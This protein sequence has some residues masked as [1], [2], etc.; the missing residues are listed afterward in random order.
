MKLRVH[1]LERLMGLIVH[2]DGDLQRK[3]KKKA[4]FSKER[5]VVVSMRTWQTCVIWRYFSFY[6]WFTYDTKHAI[7]MR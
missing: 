7:N 6:H 2:Q 1:I 4:S 3:E 5:N